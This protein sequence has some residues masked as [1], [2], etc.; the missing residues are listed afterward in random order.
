MREDAGF[1]VRWQRS[2]NPCETIRSRLVISI[3]PVSL[4]VSFFPR[5]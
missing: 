5:G 3:T 2:P 4:P 1:L